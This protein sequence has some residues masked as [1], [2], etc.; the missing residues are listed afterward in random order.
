MI[1]DSA[2]CY[3]KANVNLQSMNN[4]N[5][6]QTNK[7][8]VNDFVGLITVKSSFGRSAKNGHTRS[9]APWYQLK[10]ITVKNCSGMVWLL[11]G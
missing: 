8:C 9:P 3:K 4:I 6:F 5:L 7:N 1:K 11:V 10:K 2:G